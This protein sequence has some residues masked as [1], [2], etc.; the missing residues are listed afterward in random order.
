MKLYR[1]RQG[2]IVE[3]RGSFYRPGGTDWDELIN[4]DDVFSYLNAE[5]ARL[6]PLA[7]FSLAEADLL[8]PLESKKSGQLASPT[9][10]AEP[11]EW[12]SQKRRAVATSTIKSTLPSD[13]SSSSKPH[14]IVWPGRTSPCE[15]AA[16]LNGTSPSPNSR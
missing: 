7:D 2:V 4:R 15:Y 5:I 3:N 16:T 8:T 11:P 9:I 14:P 10:A 1:T 13:P 12:K 6:D